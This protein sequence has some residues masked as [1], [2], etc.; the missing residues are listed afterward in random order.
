MSYVRHQLPP[1][2]KKKKEKER[3]VRRKRLDEREIMY[4]SYLCLK[5]PYKADECP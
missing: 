4:Y 5:Y 3:Q 1:S 2:K